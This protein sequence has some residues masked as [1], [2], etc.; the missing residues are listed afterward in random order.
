MLSINSHMTVDVQLNVD[1]AECVLIYLLAPVPTLLFIAPHVN[2]F[3]GKYG[4]L[5]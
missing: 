5:Y 1:S 3:F 4:T 2:I